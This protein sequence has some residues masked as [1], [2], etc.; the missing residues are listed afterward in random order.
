M[1]KTATQQIL[2]NKETV[3]KFLINHRNILNRS[4]LM[5]LLHELQDQQDILKR[6]TLTGL[7]TILLQQGILE[8]I[9]ILYR[10]R[11]LYRYLTTSDY[12]SPYEIALSIAPKKAHLSHLSALFAN[13]ITNL[14]PTTIYVNYEQSVKHVD[15]KNAQ[16]TQKKVDQAFLKPVRKTKNV[17]TF[18]YRD[19]SYTV[20][21]LNGKNTNYIGVRSIKPLGFSLPVRVS[22][23]ERSLIEATIRPSYSGGVQEVLIAFRNAKGANISVNRMLSY[24]KKMNYI[25]PYPQAIYFYAYYAKY[26]AMQL[27]LIGK[28]FITTNESKQPAIKFYLD[29]QLINPKLDLESQVYYPSNFTLDT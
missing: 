11:L 14:D 15:E 13:E 9:S 21:L 26:T 4:S 5:D 29:H 18:L 12:V 20:I 16:L 1:K 3:T 25:Y 10:D 22:S 19:R 17:A 24:L 27:H 6:T 23:L 7:T 2:D 28:M 8:E